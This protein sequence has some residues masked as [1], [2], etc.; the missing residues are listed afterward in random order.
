MESQR[1]RK[2]NKMF[3]M[4]GI[5]VWMVYSVVVYWA[6]NGGQWQ[7]LWMQQCAVGWEVC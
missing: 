7:V 5:L 3:V 6:E 4:D 1:Y 2:E